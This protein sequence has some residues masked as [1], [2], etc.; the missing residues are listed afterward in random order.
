MA[1]LKGHPVR[2]GTGR[3]QGR[4][5]L[6]RRQRGGSHHSPAIG[7]NDHIGLVDTPN[8]EA[9]A[10]AVIAK[11]KEVIPSKPIRYIVAMYHHWDHLG[12]IRTAI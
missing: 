8:G 1:A 10:L 11:A 7:M 9:R 5:R 12:G 2:A 4:G 3:A 6:A